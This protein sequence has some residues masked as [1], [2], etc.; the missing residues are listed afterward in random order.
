[1]SNPVYIVD[2][3]RDVVTVTSSVLLAQLQQKDP[4]ITAVHYDYGHYTDIRERLVAKD[5]S[6]KPDE[7]YPR[8]VLFE[9]HRIKHGQE[10]LTGIADLKLLI[11]HV[12]SNKVT[13]QWREDNVFRPILYPIYFEFLKQLK[14]SGKFQIYDTTKI[15]HDQ[16]NRPH[17]GDPGLYKNEGYLLGDILDG[18]EIANLNLLTYLDNCV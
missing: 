12:S 8:I 2:I 9:D 17:W 6:G 7:K 3:M 14:L 1:M 11:L 15:Q 16:I 4:L 18:I 5:K 13:R 10:G